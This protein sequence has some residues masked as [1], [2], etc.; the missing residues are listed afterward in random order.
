MARCEQDDLPANRI[1]VDYASHSTQVEELRETLRDSLSG[2]RPQNGDIEFISTVTGAGLDTS[3]LDG[4][5][6]YA[7]LRQ[8]VLFEQA[9]RW[10]YEHGYRTFIESS[11]HPLLTGGIEESLED[12]GDD[13]SVVGT[14]R[15]NDG[16][17]RRFLLSAAELHVH[18]KSS[19]WDSMFDDMGARR[20]EL[21]TYAFERKR[22]W[23]GLG[24][25][26]VDASSLGVDAAEHPLL[27][28][29]VAQADSD[30]IIFT[31]RLSL[32][33]HPWLADHK[34]HGVVLVP[35]AAMV[36]LVLFAG[37][38]AGCPRVD[39][40]V[41][42]APLIVGEH[43][44]IA[45]QVV[46]G[47]WRETGDRR[48]RVY[49]RVDDGADRAWTQHAEGVLAPAQDFPATEEFDQWPPEG[50]EPIDVSDAYPQLA[51]RGYEYGPAFRGL[52]S[53]WRRDD[54]VFVEAALPEQVKADAGRFA[55]HPALLDAI[56]H[57]IAAGGILAESELTRLPFEWEGLSLHAVGAS[58]LRARITLVGNDT[59]AISLLDG[60]G[61]SIGRIDSLTLL[62]IPS[63]RLLMSGVADDAVYGLDW[64]TLPPSDGG[65]SDI[66]PDDVTVFRCPTTTA[67]STT[68][69]DATRRTLE[70]V[71]DRGTELAVE[72]FSR[73][74]RASRCSRTG[75]SR[76]THQKTSPISATRPCGDCC[77][78]HR[79][80]T[81]GVSLLAD[82]DDWASADVAVA[83]MASR[84]ESQL[85]F[86][87]GVCFAPR[88]VRTERIDGAEL[89]E[90][91][92]WRLAT[93]GEGTLDS[94]NFALRP[95]SRIHAAPWARRGAIWVCAPAASTSMMS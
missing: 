50:A 9:L 82:I 88:L 59:L 24:A 22:Y 28:A 90:T 55:L 60:Y 34:V 73:R 20:I 33:S 5:Y 46:V 83:E 17:M 81:R 36:E 48:V 8:P 1:P 39:Q 62:G 86:R 78:A 69:P 13:Y 30:E 10:S 84:H 40:L 70:H 26:V 72:R 61:A 15:R 47:A 11:P 31:G 51:T 80:R 44:G 25:G 32:A 94:R 56:L 29:V 79:P 71:L 52:R 3:I 6:W 93:L 21:P 63:T 12:Y 2:L 65:V 42:H 7:N 27:G 23:M 14:L 89:V 57:G 16:G 77:E 41:L 95:W 54:E 38:H 67:E 4:D 68:M 87:N 53:V 66:V 18:A 49:S 92:A 37:D 35:G 43:S 76:S 74:R 19:S 64:V 85:A 45:V 58:R 75:R 91:G